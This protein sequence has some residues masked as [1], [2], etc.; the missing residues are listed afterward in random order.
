MQPY[1]WKSKCHGAVRMIEPKLRVMY[2]Y[3]RTVD[4]I[5]RRR[6]AYVGQRKNHCLNSCG[7]KENSYNQILLDSRRMKRMKCAD[8]Q[9]NTW[10]QKRD[11]FSSL[12]NLIIVSKRIRDIE[13]TIKIGENVV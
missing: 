8:C 11:S 4:A 6:F 7:N 5:I 3:R 2:V 9:L 10:K 1:R 13:K 12:Q